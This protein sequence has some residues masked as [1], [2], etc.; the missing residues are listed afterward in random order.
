MKK[1]IVFTWIVLGTYVLFGQSNPQGEFPHNNKRQMVSL[2]YSPIT[3]TSYTA[4]MVNAL[5]EAFGSDY[6][7]IY[8]QYGVKGVSYFPSAVFGLFS[9]NYEYSIVPRLSLRVC[10]TYEQLKRKWDLYTDANSPHGFTERF[11]FYQILPELRFNY[12]KR[13]D[14]SMFLSAGFGLTYFHNTRGKFTDIIESYSG[15]DSAFQVWLLGFDVSITE[16]LALQIKALGF[17][18]IGVLELGVGYR[19]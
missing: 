2:S 19:F 12:V 15:F 5:A 7:V 10:L 8:G 4:A 9:A 6:N 17:G 3:L 14:F 18:A 13:E 11:H 1:I 16:N